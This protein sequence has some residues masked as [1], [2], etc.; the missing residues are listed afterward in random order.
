MW[1]VDSKNYPKSTTVK[2]L[3]LNKKFKKYDVLDVAEEQAS[4]TIEKIKLNGL[5]CKEIVNAQD[6]E[7]KMKTTGYSRA[8]YY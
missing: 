3:I 4:V 8:K 7:E 6:V 5:Q 2:L 1:R